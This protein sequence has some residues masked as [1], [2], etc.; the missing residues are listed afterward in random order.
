[1]WLIKM[2]DTNSSYMVQMPPIYRYPD[3]AR[4][5][6][7]NEDRTDRQ[8][9]SRFSQMKNSIKVAIIAFARASRSSKS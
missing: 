6:N 8:V 1:M 5:K 2:F 3:E 7:G 9:M 4:I